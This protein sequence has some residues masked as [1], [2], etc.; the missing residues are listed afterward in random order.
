MGGWGRV[1][2]KGWVGVGWGLRG[3]WG[4]GG[5]KQKGDHAEAVPRGTTSKSALTS[6][7]RAT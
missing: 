4:V 1:G 5:A 7:N 6:A 2:V 3:G